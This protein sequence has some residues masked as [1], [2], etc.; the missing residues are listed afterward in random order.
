MT[1]QYLTVTALTRYIKRKIDTDRHLKNIWLKG[2]ISNFNH[3]NRGHM[4][5]TLKDEGSRIQAVMFYSHNRFLKFKPEDGMHV[6][7]RGEVSVFEPY[8]QYQLYIEQMEPD[9]VGS[10]YL[11]FEQLK[12]ALRKQGYFDPAHKKPIPTFPKHIGLITSPTGAAVRD[13]LTT[14]KRRYPIVNV[15]VIP[16]IVQGELAKDSIVQSIRRANQL[17]IWDLLIVARGGGSIEDLWAFNEK[18]VA[19]AIF[20]SEIPIIS[21][22]GHETDVTISDYVADLRAPTPTA[23]AEMAV[24]SQTELRNS[25]RHMTQSLMKS[26]QQQITTY[27]QQLQR[28]N[29]SYAFR[30]P[31]HLLRQK[32]QELDQYTLR[33]K[34]AIE[35]LYNQ[36][37]ATYEHLHKRFMQQ[38][39]ER[40]LRQAHERLLDDQ[41]QL[42]QVFNLQLERKTERL[43]N[44]IDKLTLVNPLNILKR[45]FAIPYTADGSI[46]KS[47]QDTQVD[48]Q[49]HVILSDGSLTCRVLQVKGNE[50]G[51]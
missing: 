46:I 24:P 40:E 35:Q 5:M 29:Q 16:T 26:M 51:T 23:A 49:I 25:L 17:K 22:V 32:E 10:L 11:A 47:H 43:T 1:Q 34:R 7:V 45:G 38:H 44:T 48:D 41:K 28:L 13:M 33:L 39:P 36:Q 2:E 50:D 6:L 15:T 30:Y 27:E 37:V 8:G 3:H 19:Q 18:Q 4:Y 21:G 14:I 9:G 42:Q 12:E 31:I 20:E